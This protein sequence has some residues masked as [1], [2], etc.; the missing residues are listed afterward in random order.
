MFQW[1][2]VEVCAACGGASSAPVGGVDNPHAPA[3]RALG[4]A[5]GEERDE[6]LMAKPQVWFAIPSA[7]PAKC[8]KTLPAWRRQGYKIAVLQNYER[9]DIPADIA[10]WSDHYPG[11]PGS[12]NMLCKSIVPNDVQIVVSGGDDMYPD[13]DH[14]ADELAAQFLGRFPDTFGVM[15]P[16]GDEFLAARRY[17]G[18]PF[19]GRAWFETMYGGRGGMYAG[20]HHN[21][22]DNELYWVAKGLGA[23]WERPDLTHFHE[24]FTR[25]GHAAPAYWTSVRK[26]DLHDCLLYYARVHEG[27]SGHE[28]T[29]GPG[30]GRP[31]DRTLSRAEMLV[32]ADQRLL[33]VAIDNPFASAIGQGLQRCADA[34]LTP[35]ALYGM[36][37]HTQVGAAALAEPPVEISCIID[38]NSANH[39][40]TPWSIP[41][42]SREQ[43]LARGVKAVV[44]SGNSVE[45]R[46][47]ANCQV[48]RDA[49]VRVVRLYREGEGTD[50]NA[51]AGA[52]L[53]A[54]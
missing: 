14:T 24:H 6:L 19:L 9:G 33:R 32:L 45:D 52:V 42:V 3:S 5:N 27:F 48:F 39:G 50:T 31:F 44:L 47:W 12:V 15:Q 30:A 40:R 26:N 28:A 41:V 25:A 11:W 54:A 35:V 23:L 51:A 21:Y 4:L 10:V 34:G 13:A 22:A 53:A 46:L 2:G 29:T 18:S 17:C 38:D 49:G 43:A 1:G 8:R 36:G 16:H 7:S 20:Y 37:F